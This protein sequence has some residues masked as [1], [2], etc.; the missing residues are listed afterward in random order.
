MASSVGGAESVWKPVSPFLETPPVPDVPE[1]GP[2]VSS[3]SS[4]SPFLANEFE[5]DFNA[6]D[7]AGEV[8]AE[9][10]GELRE[11]DEEDEAFEETLA[12]LM[13][14]ADT[15]LIQ[16]SRSQ[17]GDRRDRR[18]R[19]RRCLR[20]HFRPFVRAM[21]ERL[22][23]TGA[24]L[25]HLDVS[26]LDE[27]ELEARIVDA[28]GR[29]APDYEDVPSEQH[30]LF[31]NFLGSLIKKAKKLAK[32]ALKVVKKVGG[33]LLSGPLGLVLRPVLKAVK[34]VA[35]KLLGKLVRFAINKVPKQYR[36][37]LR[38]IAQKLGAGAL[39]RRRPARPRTERAVRGSPAL[40][41]RNPADAVAAAPVDVSDATAA[42]AAPLDD[43]A[44]ATGASGSDTTAGD[45]S[46]VDP[47]VAAAPTGLDVAQLH[48]EFDMELLEALL[49]PDF[50]NDGEDFEDDE[51]GEDESEGEDDED[52]HQ[53]FADEITQLESGADP[54]PLVENFIGP[55][56]KVAV[57]A[58]GRKKVIKF[59]GGLLGKL[60]SPL[61]GRQHAS[62]VGRM[63]ADIGMK[64]F[65]G[66]EI[67]DEMMAE[68]GGQAIARMTMETMRQLDATPPH[69][70]ES[71]VQFEAAI[72]EAFETAAA[73]NLP[74]NLLRPEL[75]ESA[76]ADGAWIALPPTGPKRYKKYS[77]MSEV[78][79]TPQ[80]ARSIRTFGGRTIAGFL[81]DAYGLNGQTVKA[82]VHL[83]EVIS[84]SLSH[85]SAA[86]RVRGLGSR[87]R[88]A[89]AQLMP[90]TRQAVTAL[91]REPG[92]GRDAPPGATRVRP[93]AGQRFY[94]L[95]ILSPTA[96]LRGGRESG[97]RATLDFPK[98]EVRVR[99]H[100]SEVVAQEVTALLRRRAPAA[101][102][103]RM[104]K[105]VY[106]GPLAWMGTAGDK[107]SL[108][109]VIEP[110]RGPRSWVVG[111]AV[112][113][114]RREVAR[115]IQEWL[116]QRLAEYFE[117]GGADFVSAASSPKDGVRLRVTFNAPPGFSAL[118]RLFKGEASATNASPL[119]P[120][121]PAAVVRAMPGSGHG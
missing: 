42:T 118:R 2:V 77:K 44:A 96:L 99:L 49:E 26:N 104:V 46:G 97:I 75:R 80:L 58:I 108:R 79:I 114:V 116:W 39:D 106:S 105:D 5:D 33:V 103:L 57:S 90:G 47:T 45:S 51:F 86:E 17:F 12:E 7:P 85:I 94:F 112:P 84:G 18:S 70:M 115:T 91:L 89:W 81:R 119:S 1:S 87:E 24:A 83:Y 36:S 107:S 13:A 8:V 23:R 76:A 54:Q 48:D 56:V 30:A 63:L 73:A 62:G 74:P 32:G 4:E 9:L 34:K 101:Q 113:A 11:D 55:V 14:E 29:T 117:T 52:A 65:F 71:P 100:L 110:P 72:T 88:K 10:L 35:K 98:N 93:H 60:I 27:D 120:R 53:T 16:G 61:I 43:A 82:R 15:A 25:E 20:E 78:E 40:A 37:M 102:V 69:V 3:F 31:E 111:R 21:E 41:P 66:A 6:S 92:L 68:A 67:S 38:S 64:T 59:I 95:E 121:A 28:Y 109:A 50:A 19:R 22:D